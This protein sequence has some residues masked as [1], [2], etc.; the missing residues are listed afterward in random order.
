LDYL[1]ANQVTEVTDHAALSSVLS[2]QCPAKLRTAWIYALERPASLSQSREHRGPG[3]I[4]RAADRDE[5]DGRLLEAMGSPAR[6]LALAQWAVLYAA[7]ALAWAIELSSPET[8][9]RR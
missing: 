3:R 8:M 6:F 5:L 1:V 4:P 7:P 2:I 9:A